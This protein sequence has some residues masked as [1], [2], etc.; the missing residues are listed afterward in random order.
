[1]AP[2]ATIK[3]HRLL[4][5]IKIFATVINNGSFDMSKWDLKFPGSSKAFC[6]AA[7][8]F[9]T[10]GNVFTICYAAFC[11]FLIIKR[12][13]IFPK[14]II[15]LYAYWV[16]FHLLVLILLQSAG[17]KTDT[18]DGKALMR[19]IIVAAIWML[20]FIK[21]TRLQ[22]TFIVPYP[23]N[24]YVFDTYPEPCQSPN[25]LKKKNNGE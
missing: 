25:K 3:W 21:S 4:L 20:Y 13:D 24:K 23:V 17:A 10:F 15:G 19:S 16:V 9:E 12:R 6:N 22:K 1:M 5:E 14:F 11:F 2:A 18:D 7:F 8:T